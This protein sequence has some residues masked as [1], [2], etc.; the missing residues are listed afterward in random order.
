MK[1]LEL[2]N[3]KNVF[4]SVNANSIEKIKKQLSVSILDL[5]GS[6]VIEKLMDD[7]LLFCNV[8][9]LL[10]E[11]SCKELKISPEEFAENIEGEQIEKATVAFIE[12]LVSFL[13]PH[14]RAILQQSLKMINEL[15]QKAVELS[16]EK[17]QSMKG[18]MNDLM[19]R[20]ID[21]TMTKVENSL[22]TTSLDS[23]S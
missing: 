21:K 12:D 17:M 19:I 9:Y 23:S 22:I 8:I 6:G 10:C 11:T 16:M 5:N 7:Q 13:P 2:K 1:Q 20:E 15:N 3:K 14:R 4:L 18:K